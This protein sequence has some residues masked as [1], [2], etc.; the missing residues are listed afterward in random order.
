MLNLAYR[1]GGALYSWRYL[2]WLVVPMVAII[3]LS[4]GLI[5]LAQGMDRL[6]NPRVRARHAKSIAGES[7]GED[8]EDSTISN[9]PGMG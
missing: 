1:T 7:E 8:E 9:L 6:F 2:H 3:G 5:L 4:L